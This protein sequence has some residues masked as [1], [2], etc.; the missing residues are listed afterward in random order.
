ME[1]S[2]DGLESLTQ[3]TEGQSPGEDIA[4]RRAIE[5]WRRCAH[6]QVLK[7]T[8]PLLHGTRHREAAF[9]QTH[10]LGRLRHADAAD[11]AWEQW[12][13][14]AD[15]PPYRDLLELI[16]PERR[17]MAQEASLRGV[18]VLAV[19]D[20][21]LIGRAYARV[22]W[23]SGAVCEVASSTKAALERL[24]RGCF[25]VVVSDYYR[26]GSNGLSLLAA[27]RVLY[28]EMPLVLHS[29]GMTREVARR[30]ICEFGVD[31]VVWKPDLLRVVSMIG[32]LARAYSHA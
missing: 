22:L 10:A 9:L 15:A 1:R 25:D 11:D 26:P 14:G 19:D 24:E 30:A 31:R 23:A 27:C 4:L 28:P 6:E 8:T 29:G 7:W 18:R 13:C 21:L 5:A 2:L 16:H 17:D 32:D 3:S 20:D 12:S